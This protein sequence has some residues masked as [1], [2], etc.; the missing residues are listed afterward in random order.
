MAGFSIPQ[1]RVR[2]YAGRGPARRV[3][4]W[5]GKDCCSVQAPAPPAAGSLGRGRPLPVLYLP[6]DQLAD[7]LKLAGRQAHRLLDLLAPTLL[8]D[9][10]ELQDHEV[11]LIPGQI[12]P[13]FQIH[14]VH[15]GHRC[16]LPL[17][18]APDERGQVAGF[19]A[20]LAEAPLLSKKLRD[21]SSRTRN[22]ISFAQLPHLTS[23]SIIG[24]PSA[25][26]R[27]AGFAMSAAGDPFAAVLSPVIR[28]RR[29]RGRVT[30]ALATN[31][32]EITLLCHS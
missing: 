16:S 15:G 8:L 2:R 12:D 3:R 18:R 27:F 17:G 24:L 4:G 10:S 29:A 6:P 31:P 22:V 5:W 25:H 7:G 30:E 26:R 11:D 23:N 19:V 20:D 9:R 14:Q 28:N 32:F 1:C 13:V 21:C